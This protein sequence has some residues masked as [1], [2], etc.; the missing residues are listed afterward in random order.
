MP[1]YHVDKVFEAFLLSADAQAKLIHEVISQNLTQHV[2]L[3]FT[4]LRIKGDESWK[5]ALNWY[6]TKSPCNTPQNIYNFDCDIHM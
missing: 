3:P 1:F 2:S 5:P 6:P 4:S